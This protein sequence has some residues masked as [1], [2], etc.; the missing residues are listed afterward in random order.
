[1]Y[2]GENGTTELLRPPNNAR[3]GERVTFDGID[4]S[5]GGIATPNNLNKGAG[6]KAVEAI[7]TDADF[8]TNSSREATFRSCTMVTTAG[9]VTVKT[10]NNAKI[11]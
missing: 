3:V 8:K 4:M 6:K 7:L 1:M 9:E 5:L 2:E 10:V 11:K